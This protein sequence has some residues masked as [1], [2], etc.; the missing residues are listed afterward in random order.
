LFYSSLVPVGSDIF[1]RIVVRASRVPL[2]ETTN[3]NL[4]QWTEQALYE[5]CMN[6]AAYEA[7]EKKSAARK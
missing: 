6:P 5:V 4:T 1:R 2:V 3:F 7:V